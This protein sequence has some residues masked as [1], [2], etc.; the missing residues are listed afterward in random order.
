MSGTDLSTRGFILLGL[1]RYSPL[2][3]AIIAQNVF[4]YVG[5]LSEIAEL[6]GCLT[7]WG[8]IGLTLTLG[9]LGDLVALKTRNILGLAIAHI[10]L[11]VAMMIFI[12]NL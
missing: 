8:A 5:H 12:R 4:W 9:I 7:L 6:S 2:I 1:A 11:N 10:L 3:F